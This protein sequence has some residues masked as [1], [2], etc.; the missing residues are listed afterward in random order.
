[1]RSNPTRATKYIHEAA[2]F[3]EQSGFWIGV[4]EGLFPTVDIYPI[5]RPNDSILFLQEE[6]AEEFIAEAEALMKRYPSLDADTAYLS[7]AKGY[8]ENACN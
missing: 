5:K 7:L 6:A 4:D 8:V 3:V 2:D 1:M